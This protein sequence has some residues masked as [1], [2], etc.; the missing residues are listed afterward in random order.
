MP[1]D[2]GGSGA[3]DRVNVGCGPHHRLEG[4]LNV[5]V[6]PFSGVDRVIDA[7]EPW[8][9]PDGSV[10]YVYAEH[11]LEHLS[12]REAFDFLLHAGQALRRGGRIRLST[13]NLEW[14]MASHFSLDDAP[15]RRRQTLVVNRAFYGWGHRFLWSRELL[16]HVLARTGFEDVE[17]FDYGQSDDPN[18]RGLERHGGYL[19]GAGRPSVVIV[20]A[21]KGNREIA[22]DPHLL[23]WVDEEFVRHV[24]AGH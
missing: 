6:R 12:I 17:F 18:L 10:S 9:I 11:F 4:W 22:V 3:L 24:G 5:D 8:P 7:T 23:D 20:E 1:S 15:E 13:P 2:S 14:V 21:A 19:V 16:D